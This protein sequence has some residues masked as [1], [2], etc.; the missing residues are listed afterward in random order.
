MT[1]VTLNGE[2]IKLNG[3]LPKIGDELPEFELVDN[4][5]N[6]CHLADFQGKKKLLNIVPSIDTE[7]CANS[8]RKFEDAVHDRNDVIM[9]VVSSDLPFA[10]KR[11]CSG[12]GV[13][14][15]LLLSMMRS[16]DFARSYGMLI[17]D[18][19]LAGLTGRAVIVADENNKVIYTELVSEITN[20]PDYDKA[21]SFLE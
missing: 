13:D 1:T 18:G 6:S 19:P 12:K 20:E 4:K 21:I 7:V 5:L 8:A 10:Q 11:F 3:N 15:V 2:N 14:H 17:E 16:K 9:L